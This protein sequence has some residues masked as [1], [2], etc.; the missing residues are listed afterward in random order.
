MRLVSRLRNQRNNIIEPDLNAKET[1]KI[2]YGQ[3]AN[4]EYFKLPESLQNK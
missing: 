1:N 4:P 3:P 2:D